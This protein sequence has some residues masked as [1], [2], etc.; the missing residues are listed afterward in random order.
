[1]GHG[2]TEVDVTFAP[3]V[4]TSIGNETYGT[5]DIPVLI[6]NLHIATAAWIKH[7]ASGTG[8][9]AVAGRQPF[10]DYS[11]KFTVG[12]QQWKDYTVNADDL[13]GLIYN[14]DSYKN[15]SWFSSSTWLE[16]DLVEA[17]ESG[18][19]YYGI[20]YDGDVIKRWNYAHRRDYRLAGRG[21]ALRG[22]VS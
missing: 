10:S 12:D 9:L 14:W 7:M 5:I 21:V 19:A 13:Y 22:R 3:E 18:N 16:T 4:N 1:V 8:I 15:K 20:R 2:N 11:G 6:L 17:A